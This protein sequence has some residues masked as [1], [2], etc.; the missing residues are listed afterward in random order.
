MTN[1]KDELINHIKDRK[2]IHV[3]FK[4]GTYYKR[5]SDVEFSGSLE[6]ALSLL[7]FEYASGFGTQELEGIIWYEDGTWSNRGEYD[8]SE[9]WEYNKCPPIP[10]KEKEHDEAQRKT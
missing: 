9:W 10:K 2:V 1:A 6:D 8:G 7:N 3:W 5:P 4:F